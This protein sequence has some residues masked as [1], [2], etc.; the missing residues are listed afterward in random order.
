MKSSGHHNFDDEPRFPHNHNHNR[1][2]NLST[3]QNPNISI[4]KTNPK[5]T[6]TDS[7]EYTINSQ[8]LSSQTEMSS[9]NSYGDFDE[10]N[11]NKSTQNETENGSKSINTFD[12]NNRKHKKKQIAFVLEAIFKNCR[13]RTKITQ[14][15]CK[16]CLYDA[17]LTDFGSLLAPCKCRGNLRYIHEECLKTYLILRKHDLERTSCESCKAQISMKIEYK[18][19]FYPGKILK[20]GLISFVIS[21]LL[22]G[23]ILPIIPPDNI[24]LFL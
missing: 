7:N 14:K 16:L 21:V 20:E 15:I 9:Y 22:F 19:C 18:S 1:K 23:L 10:K 13:G 12:D 17:S 11:P 24:S 5:M 2:E 4:S 8:I 3:N 6:S